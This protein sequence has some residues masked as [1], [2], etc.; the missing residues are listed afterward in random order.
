[1][2]DFVRHTKE[3]R[4]ALGLQGSSGLAGKTLL[5]RQ[6]AGLGK[7]TGWSDYELTKM[8]A[9]SL[10]E[11]AGSLGAWHDNSDQVA[12]D[13]DSRDCGLMQINIPFRLVGTD[14]EARLRTE[15]LNESE[16]G[17]VAMNN[18][19][20]GMQ[21]Y[22][23]PWKRGGK[24]DIRRW[25]P[26]VAYTT[27]WATF[28]Y[29]WVWHQEGGVPVG[30][31][32]PTGRYIHR[33]IAGQMN[34]HVAILKGWS[35]EKALRVAKQYYVPHFGVK[36]VTYAVVNGLVTPKYDPAP[37]APPADRVGPRPVPNDGV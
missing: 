37:T 3:Q 24:T 12:P 10:G 15:S 11:S 4:L 30:P 2:T 19:A 17:P 34:Y 18:A 26:W 21:L 20:H 27:G 33:A 13:P 36:Q 1:M 5:P 31:W 35:P 8:V 6:I 23:T 28:P 16:W 9:T 22:E 7:D 32:L 29:A 25:Q 14:A